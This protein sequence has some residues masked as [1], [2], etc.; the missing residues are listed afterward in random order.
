MVI[1]FLG[2]RKIDLDAYKNNGKYEFGNLKHPTAAAAAAAAS[3]TSASAS[4]LG[5]RR[6]RRRRRHLIFEVKTYEVKTFVVKS[7][8]H[9]SE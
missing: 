7:L 9:N 2:C 8:I 3:P 6:M 1:F 5:L 4:A